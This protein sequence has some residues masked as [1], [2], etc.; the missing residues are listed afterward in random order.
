MIKQI[1]QEGMFKAPRSKAESKADSTDSAARSIIN[2]EVASREAKTAKLREARLAR[3]ALELE[4]A[5][6]VPAGKTP[7]RAK[8]AKARTK[9]AA[10]A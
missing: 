6:A 2:A 8:S 9:L 4:N 1:A 3:E 10:K 5:P 7:A